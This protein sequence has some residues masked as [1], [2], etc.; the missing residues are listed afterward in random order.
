MVHIGLIENQDISHNLEQDPQ[1]LSQGSSTLSTTTNTI[2]Q[3]PISRNYDPPPLP[4]SDTYTSSSKSQ[5]PSSFNNKINGLISNT[6]LRFSF[7]SP[8]PPERT[9]VTTHPYTQAQNTSD[10]NMT[11]TFNINL[12]HTNPSL[13]IVTSRTLP[14]PPLQTIPYNPLQYKFYSTNTHNP[15]YFIQSPEQNAQINPSNT[16]DQHHNVP[17]PSTSSS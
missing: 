16:S 17:M 7:Q 2:P 8:S 15:H 3:P 14:R 5:Q 11:T 12:I 13:N 4:E 10:P 1:Y 9:S 6:R